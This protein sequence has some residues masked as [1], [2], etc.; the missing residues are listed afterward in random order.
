MGASELRRQAA[1]LQGAEPGPSKSS[2]ICVLCSC[3][4]S[5]IGRD[6]ELLCLD[7][8]PAPLFTC[9]YFC[10]PWKK[11]GEGSA[12]LAALYKGLCLARSLLSPKGMRHNIERSTCVSTQCTNIMVFIF[13]IHDL[14]HPP[15][16]SEIWDHKTESQPGKKGEP[17][18]G[19]LLGPTKLRLYSQ[20][21]SQMANN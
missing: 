2:P 19:A 9:V 7:S 6:S 10:I 20:M 4:V 21:G 15:S 1:G 11:C 13:P 12:R 3:L 18:H 14:F 8:V 16:H 5:K 17:W